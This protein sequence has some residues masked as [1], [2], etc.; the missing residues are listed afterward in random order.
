MATA[1]VLSLRP[2][3]F[4]TRELVPGP[5]AKLEIEIICFFHFPLTDTNWK[6]IISEC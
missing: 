2:V 4:V 1:V 6:Q 3:P 5:E